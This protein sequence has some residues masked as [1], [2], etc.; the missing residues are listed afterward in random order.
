MAG[1]DNTDPVIEATDSFGAGEWTGGWP[2]SPAQFP[3]LIQAFQGCLLRYAARRLGSLADAE[4]VVQEVFVKAYAERERRRGVVHVRAYLYRMTAN[5]CVSML[6]HRNRGPVPL[7]DDI[8]ETLHDSRP[9]ASIAAIAGQQSQQLA[10]LLGKLPEP[11][12]ETIRLRYFD[13]LS[14]NEIAEVTGATLP[15]VKSRMR[16]GL[17]RLHDLIREEA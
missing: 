16:Y 8:A 9:L 13:E 3:A 7:D 1:L 6:R 4:D 10:R 14:L 2:Q 12:A 5:A 15:A 17:E 11:Q